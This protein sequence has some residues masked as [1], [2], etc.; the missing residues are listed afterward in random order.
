MVGMVA[1]AS[2]SSEIVD[3]A[4]RQIKL[5]LNPPTAEVGQ[6][7][8]GKVVNITKFGA[9]VNILP[10]RDGLV[11]I[12]K[13]GGNRRIDRVEDEVDLG[14]EIEVRVDDVDPQG[15]ISL[16]PTSYEGGG[17]STAAATIAPAG[18]IVADAVVGTATVAAVV[19][20]T[21]AA[22]VVGTGTGTAIAT[23]EV[24][25]GD[26]DAEGRPPPSRIGSRCSFEDKF[27]DGLE[28][29]P[30]RPGPLVGLAA[31]QLIP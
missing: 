30:R 2:T 1:I 20:V 5:I 13:L 12:S 23:E 22:V 7:Y 15:K 24:S 19:V 18:A 31:S 29:G 21:V 28:D 4:E 14:D 10:G 3:E 26:S 17:R 27:E 9:F 16:T 11:H 25:R 6:T 8:T